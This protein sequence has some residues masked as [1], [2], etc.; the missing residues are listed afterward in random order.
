MNSLQALCQQ[1]FMKK[2]KNMCRKIL[3]FRGFLLPFLFKLAQNL[4]HPPYW[5]VTDILHFKVQLS[6]LLSH[7]RN[8]LVSDSHS[9][10]SA[11]FANSTLLFCLL[12]C[13][14]FCFL[15][16]C[17]LK[18]NSTMDIV[19]FYVYGKIDMTEAIC[20]CV[21]IPLEPAGISSL[22]AS[23]DQLPQRSLSSTRMSW[24]S[25]TL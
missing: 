6:Q 2:Y 22:R 4:L 5:T 15:R 8:I 14:V 21:S 24:P 11:V 3:L 20:F 13:L 7:L 16:H 12:V 18:T 9:G 25:H 17:N 1:T 19:L 23:S 10:E